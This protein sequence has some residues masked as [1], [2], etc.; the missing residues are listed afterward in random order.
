MRITALPD[1]SG[2]RRAYHLC[3]GGLFRAE[4]APETGGKADPFLAIQISRPHIPC[5]LHGE[6]PGSPPLFLGGK[7]VGEVAIIGEDLALEFLNLTIPG[8]YHK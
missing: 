2:C 7:G 3:D 1:P 6:I 5:F 8:P 4:R